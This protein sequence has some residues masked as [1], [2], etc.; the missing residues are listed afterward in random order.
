M[1]AIKTYSQSYCDNTW[2]AENTKPM[3]ATITPQS[4]KV[5]RVEWIK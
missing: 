1:E 4:A 2:C 3:L 5:K